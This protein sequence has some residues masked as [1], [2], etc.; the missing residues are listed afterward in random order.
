MLKNKY[1]ACFDDVKGEPA[2]LEKI[3]GMAE[4]TSKDLKRIKLLSVTKYT[5]SVAAAA[6]VVVSAAFLYNSGLLEAD[7]VKE[8]VNEAKNYEHKLTDKKH[9]LAEK[10]SDNT[11]DKTAEVTL[12]KD[13]KAE[14]VKKE[15]QDYSVAQKSE[16]KSRIAEA[17]EVQKNGSE[18][19]ILEDTKN[20]EIKKIL[21]EKTEASKNEEI[22]MAAITPENGENEE[23]SDA[24]DDNTQVKLASGGGGGS[25]AAVAR[26]DE[27]MTKAYDGAETTAEEKAEENQKD[28]AEK[29]T[30]FREGIMNIPENEYSDDNKKILVYTN[31]DR[32]K[33][34]E[35]T[36]IKRKDKKP[37]AEGKNLIETRQGFVTIEAENI[38]QAYL[39][40]IILYFAEK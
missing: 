11:S 5:A 34:I 37:V 38:S 10:T 29:L 21:P 4:D 6:V 28:Y 30:V 17:E 27:N 14:A 24:E 13:I 1:K 19:E 40:E 9:Q 32:T 23:I 39:D 7:V 8:N 12:E 33:R 26:A 3:L 18:E 2:L 25:S 20:V 31:E 35:L 22:E 36:F 16:I 15:N